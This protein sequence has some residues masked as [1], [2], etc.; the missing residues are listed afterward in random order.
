MTV[1]RPQPATDVLVVIDIQPAM[2]AAIWEPE[3]VVGGAIFLARVARELGIPVLATVQNPDRLGA[4]HP[5]VAPWVDETVP[6]MAFSAM[7][8]QAFREALAETGRRQA[9]LV[10]VETHICVCQTALDLAES[11]YD[12]LVCPDAVSA[13][14]DVRHKLGM[15]RLRDA[16]IGPIHSEAVLYEWL[17]TAAHPKFRDVLAIVKGN[18]PPV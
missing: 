10:G 9:I 1:S 12:V 15:E 4:L 13:R 2:M 5:D 3:R 18:K 14:N 8:D 17:Q 7:G 11:S 6:K 16:G